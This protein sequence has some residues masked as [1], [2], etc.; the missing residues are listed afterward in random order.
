MEIERRNLTEEELK[1]MKYTIKKKE[2]N[3]KR[4]MDKRQQR[5]KEIKKNISTLFHS[6][7]PIQNGIQ[8]PEKIIRLIILI[9]GALAIY[10]FYQHFKKFQ[11]IFNIDFSYWDLS[12]VKYFHPIILLITIILFWKRNKIG[13][14]LLSSILTFAVMNTIVSFFQTSG[15]RLEGGA[16]EILFLI[17]VITLLFYGSFLFLIC[18]QGVL[19]IFKISRRTMFATI[20]LAMIVNFIFI[21][22]IGK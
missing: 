22:L 18:K 3:Q 13:W 11:I 6:I 20:A 5:E 15:R 4:E 16:F 7:N 14:I 9:F 1:Q 21:Y 17:V 19:N 10:Q 12:M 2:N 8:T